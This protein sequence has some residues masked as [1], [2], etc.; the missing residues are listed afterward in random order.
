MASQKALKRSRNSRVM[1]HRVRIQQEIL[2][3]P[4]SP[5]PA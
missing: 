1:R 5:L 2:D 4:P 3:E